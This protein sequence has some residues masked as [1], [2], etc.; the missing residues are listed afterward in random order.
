MLLALF[1]VSINDKDAPQYSLTWNVLN[2]LRITFEKQYVWTGRKEGHTMNFTNAAMPWYDKSY[3][4][5]ISVCRHAGRPPSESNNKNVKSD[6]QQ[7]VKQDILKQRHV[8]LWVTCLLLYFGV[9]PKRFCDLN[10][11]T[12]SAQH[13]TCLTGA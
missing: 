13:L 9:K 3:H 2:S 12:H 6:G 8:C 7:W 4:Y 11:G 1:L 10:R 5:R